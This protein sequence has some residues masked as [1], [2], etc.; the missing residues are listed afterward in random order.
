VKEALAQRILILSEEIADIENFISQVII[1]HNGIVPGDLW[2]L[3][4]DNMILRSKKV[5]AKIELQM[6]QAQF[7]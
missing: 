1:S 5:S 6:L 7:S 2:S 4:Y 3:F